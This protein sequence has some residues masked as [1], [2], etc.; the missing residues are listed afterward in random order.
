MQ[1]PC[2]YSIYATLLDSYRNMVESDKVWLTYWGNSKEPPHTMEQFHWL[3]VEQFI[4][5]I[6]HVDGEPSYHSSRGTAFNELIDALV[7]WR[8][9]SIKAERGDGVVTCELDGFEFV[10]PTTLLKAVAARYAGA[11][12]QYLTSGTMRTSAGIVRL[13]G[14]VDELLPDMVVDIKTTT[15][16]EYPKFADN[17]QHLVYPWC[18]RQ[19]GMMLNTFRYDVVVFSDYA[20]P[21]MFEEVYNWQDDNERILRERV[22]DVCGWIDRYR[23]IIQNP[24]IF[25]KPRAADFV[26]VPVAEVSRAGLDA[27][28]KELLNNINKTH[29]ELEQ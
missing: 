12:C 22:E 26:G 3:Q 10:F 17:A 5:G 1:L 19:E 25:G 29:L 9:P 11:V 21:E 8:K 6:N 16:Y 4:D 7:E 24:S 20:A 13:Y 2:D 14:Y 23:A 18:L 28:C 15:R 27:D